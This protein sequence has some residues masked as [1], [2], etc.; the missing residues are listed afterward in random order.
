MSTRIEPASTT[1]D[2]PP[3]PDAGGD[4][5]AVV[6]DDQPTTGWRTRY[7]RGAD[8][9]AEMLA[10]VRRD[11]RI[12]VA[13][14][15]GD[16]RYSDS[17][18]NQGIGLDAVALAGAVP[19]AILAGWLVH[20]GHLAGP[21]LAFIP[22]TFATYMAP[23]YIVG[24]DYLGLPGNN[25]RFFVFHLALFITG[26]AATVLAWRSIDPA[27][28]RPSTDNSDRRRSLVLFGVVALILGGRWLAGIIDLLGGDPNSIDYL[29]NP[30]AY[31]LI[32][33]LDLG[34]IV[35]AAIVTAFALR[36]H[37][38]WAR[39]ATYAV[40]G[41]FALVP[42]AVAAM[43]IVMTANNDPNASTA[44]TVTFVVAAAALTVA[45]AALYRPILPRAIGPHRPHQPRAAERPA[46][47]R[48]TTEQGATP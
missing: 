10:P 19:I 24:P 46:P 45:A 32:R 31:V 14:A 8:R 38:P 26:I 48:L 4:E 33:V 13:P 9:A 3:R 5:I 27:Q 39:T 6:A 47:D 34:I 12:G 40:I 21:V 41:W 7:R 30:T 2:H 28:L 20:R 18:T 23:Q 44:A 22:A 15:V 29:E 36:R 11:R 17:F 42:A 1:A 37:R 43:A 16:Y 25:E 35:P